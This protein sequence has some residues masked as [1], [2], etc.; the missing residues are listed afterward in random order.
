MRKPDGLRLNGDGVT[1]NE[2]PGS[3]LLYVLL[4]VRQQLTES[5]YGPSKEWTL[6]LRNCL[7][8]VRS[9]LQT[10]QIESWGYILF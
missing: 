9:Y 8:L 2:L 6:G 4:N 3:V 7:E 10:L 1:L 5:R